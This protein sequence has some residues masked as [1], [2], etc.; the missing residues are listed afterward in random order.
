MKAKKSLTSDLLRVAARQYKQGHQYA[1]SKLGQE[2]PGLNGG[3]R[4]P[5]VD[6]GR[7]QSEIRAALSNSLSRYTGR[8]DAE[9]A[10]SNL[11]IAVTKLAYQSGLLAGFQLQSMRPQDIVRQVVTGALGNKS[12]G[13]SA[14]KSVVKLALRYSA[15]K[16]SPEEL[17]G[18]LSP[19][20]MAVLKRIPAGMYGTSQKR[21]GVLSVAG[22]AAGNRLIKNGLVKTT[23]LILE[24][25]RHAIALTPLGEQVKNALA[26][27]SKIHRVTPN[28]EA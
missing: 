3:K 2:D 24:D 20:E 8:T 14:E 10:Q 4:I 19:G 17:A 18:Q 1:T 25:E 11:K 22:A 23:A 28:K 15:R 21:A 13:K 12:M 6:A 7:I 27:K 26:G 16:A 9:R 5:A